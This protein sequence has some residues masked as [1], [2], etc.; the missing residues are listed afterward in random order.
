MSQMINNT[1]QP[2][3][4]GFSTGT[5]SG[6]PSRDLPCMH[7]LFFAFWSQNLGS[8]TETVLFSLKKV[9]SE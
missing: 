5:R 9:K 6:K 1:I 7:M 4:G 3:T 2:E 8:I